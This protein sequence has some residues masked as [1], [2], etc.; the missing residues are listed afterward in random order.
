MLRNQTIDDLLII[1]IKGTV[2]ALD[3]ESGQEVWRTPLKGYDF[4]N[5]TREGD[6]IFAAARGEIFALDALTGRLLWNNPLKGMGFGLVTFATSPQVAAAAQKSL[7][8]ASHAAT[9][10]TT[11]TTMQNSMP[12]HQPLP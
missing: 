6:R 12:P 3:A 9:S 11:Q 7:N 4:T 2:L 10:M 8:D 5:V 1:G